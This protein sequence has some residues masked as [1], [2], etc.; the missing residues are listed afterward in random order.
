MVG[1]W[2]SIQVEIEKEKQHTRLGIFQDRHCYLKSTIKDRK[3][4]CAEKKKNKRSTQSK[5]DL[6][7][8]NA[9][10]ESHPFIHQQSAGTGAASADFEEAIHTS[11]AATSRGNSDEDKM[12]E[13][14][15]RASVL[16]LKLASE[17]GDHADALQRA[18][19]A[20]VTEASQFRK[21][22]S[23]K[24]P[25]NG[26]IEAGVN[27]EELEATLHRNVSQQFSSGS[28]PNLAAI[29]FDDSGV[30]TD[31]DGNITAAIE[32]SRSTKTSGPK[33][34]QQTDE[35]L[36]K[37]IELSKETKEEHEQIL[38]KS[39]TEEEIVLA[40]VK[41]QSLAEEQHKSSIIT[42][43]GTRHDLRD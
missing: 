29:D 43:Q 34:A 16:E 40:Y 1:R 32:R 26:S 13:K 36:E 42:K 28:S 21:T 37:A 18:I 2:Q 41:R 7:S 33:A 30:D 20:S 27:D 8:P 25:A 23:S 9:I 5:D 3:R 4:Q 15:I 24:P 17:E 22:D 38:S 39:N 10:P 19:Q 11:V 14:A 35:D 6:H 12:I 31:D